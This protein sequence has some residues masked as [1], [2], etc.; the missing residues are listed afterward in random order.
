MKEHE[1]RIDGELKVEIEGKISTLREALV[2]ENPED[3]RSAS[4]DLMQVM[5]KIGESVYAQNEATTEQGPAEGS[6]SE[7]TE[8]QDESSED[9]VEGDYREA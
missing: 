9:T 3:I 4:D 8:S 7:E 6:N 5:T 1:E 2:T